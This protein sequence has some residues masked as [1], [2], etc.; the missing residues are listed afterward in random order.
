MNKNLDVITY[1]VSLIIK[2]AILAARFPGRV[3]SPQAE[4]AVESGSQQHGPDEQRNS[5]VEDI[6]ILCHASSSKAL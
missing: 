6:E 1:T 4:P 3:L 2:A 5:R